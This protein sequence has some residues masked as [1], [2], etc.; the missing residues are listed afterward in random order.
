VGRNCWRVGGVRGDSWRI[1]TLRTHWIV[2]GHVR[3][4]THRVALLLLLRIG[5]VLLLVHT[6]V[7]AVL[8][9]RWG[10]SLRR[11]LDNSWN[12]KEKF[13]TLVGN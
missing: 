7:R 3:V 11:L 2:H 9:H 4:A 5:W 12:N 13:K 1:S 10:L 8:W 6:R